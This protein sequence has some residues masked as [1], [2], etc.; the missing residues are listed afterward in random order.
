MDGLDHWRICDELSV[1]QAALL[2]AGLDPGEE[3]V[4]EYVEE[5]D[6]HK[7]PPGYDAAKSALVN[8]IQ[9]GRLSATLRHRGRAR[10]E[11][12]SEQLMAEI[13]F[14]DEIEIRK[15]WLMRE[16]EPRVVRI[17]S[18]TPAEYESGPIFICDKVP[19]WHYS[20]VMVDDLLRA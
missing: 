3:C 15:T 19:N 9:G 8:A 14:G 7:R 6:A 20:T 16:E 10:L 18:N 17:K 2:I 13:P 5:W 12:F 11:E 4:G 1:I